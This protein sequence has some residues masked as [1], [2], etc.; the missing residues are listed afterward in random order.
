M[1]TVIKGPVSSDWFVARWIEAGMKFF[2]PVTFG[3]VFFDV[4]IGNPYPGLNISTWIIART[5]RRAI[6]NFNLDI[7]GKVVCR[8]PVISCAFACILSYSLE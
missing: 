3:F 8:C 6:V 5:D 4:V 2:L 7:F 1:N